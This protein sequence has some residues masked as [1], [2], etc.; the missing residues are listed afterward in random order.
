[1]IDLTT[2]AAAIDMDIAVPTSAVLIVEALDNDGEMSVYVAT[3][4][5]VPHWQVVGL[6]SW[7]MEQA[8][9]NGVE[10]DD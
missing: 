9:R 1:M 3:S 4:D 2:M 7:A 5:G 6:C 10:G 8:R